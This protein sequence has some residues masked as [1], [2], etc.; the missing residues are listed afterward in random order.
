MQR[1]ETRLPDDHCKHTRSTGGSTPRDSF[2][3]DLIW[4]GLLLA[5]LY[6]LGRV[7]LAGLRLLGVE[8][9]Q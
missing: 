7:L 5:F 6:G 8:P 3:S 2:L 1:D 4:L 9:F